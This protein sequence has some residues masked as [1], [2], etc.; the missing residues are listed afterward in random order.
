MFACLF[1]I[2]NL[3]L[4]IECG[5]AP[6]HLFV[7][8]VGP[9]FEANNSIVTISEMRITRKLYD[10]SVSGDLNISTDIDDGWTIKVCIITTYI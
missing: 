7:T 10:F 4:T 9:C 5:V 3:I 6:T 2:I 1:L 8:R